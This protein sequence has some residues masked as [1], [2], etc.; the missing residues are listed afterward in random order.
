M[1]VAQPRNLREQAIVEAALRSKYPQMYREQPAKS[2]KKKK[3]K[4]ES[5]RE[6][7]NR[8]LR[9]ALTGDEIKRVT[10]R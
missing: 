6:T 3:E 7:E 5:R 4:T 2:K 10:G 8:I 1:A 9:E